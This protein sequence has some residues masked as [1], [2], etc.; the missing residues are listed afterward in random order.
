MEEERRIVAKG[1]KS[2]GGVIWWSEKWSDD[3]TH[4]IAF[5]DAEM[6]RMTEKVMSALAAGKWIVTVRFVKK[7]LQEGKWIC[8]TRY[9]WNDRASERR[10][11]IQLKGYACG[12]L[13]WRMKAGFIM[14]DEKNQDFV[15]RLV[16]AGGGKVVTDYSSIGSLINNLP[17]LY[18][19]LTH[20]FVDDVDELVASRNFRYLVR[21]SASRKLGIKFLKFKFIYD[22]ISG[23]DHYLADWNI[24][25][26]FQ[27][28]TPSV[29]QAMKRPQDSAGPSGVEGAVKRLRLAAHYFRTEKEAKARYRAGRKD[30]DIREAAFGK[31]IN[32]DPRRQESNNRQV[33]VFKRYQDQW[34]NNVD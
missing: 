25:D 21:E 9:L 32:R 20:V 19:M 13:F 29:E 28:Q 7:S 4:V 12:Q 10:K 22:M 26:R 11:E 31:K 14:K 5:S 23:R 1:I 8:P 33:V 2:L 27:N 24:A 3:I 17:S 6:E 18:R 16:R 15:E 30:G 34:V